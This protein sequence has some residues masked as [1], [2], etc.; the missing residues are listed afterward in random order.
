MTDS[1]SLE[2]LV[3]AL[4]YMRKR[5]RLQAAGMRLAGREDAA[6]VLAEAADDLDD[7]IGWQEVHRD[8][9]GF[10]VR[11]AGDASVN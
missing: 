4:K 3:E 9:P 6:V 1:D 8:G 10:D 2:T 7:M 11:R 5:F